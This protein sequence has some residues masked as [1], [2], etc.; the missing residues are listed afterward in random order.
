MVA[1]MRNAGEACTAAN[2]FYVEASVAQEF[3]RRLAARMSALVVGPGTQERTEVGPLVN[4]DA[5]S[6]VDE[7]VR[8][9]LI[10]GAQALV[11]GHR[12]EGEG[13]YY[14][15]TVLVNV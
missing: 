15:P 2:R 8:A 4:Q 11:G 5:V 13:F 9:A 10:E 3:G 1:K 12:P 6:K 7:L 14:E